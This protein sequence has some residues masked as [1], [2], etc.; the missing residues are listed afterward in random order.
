MLIQPLDVV[1]LESGHL[2][3]G[4]RAN[5]DSSG[6][7][8]CGVSLATCERITN[9]DSSSSTPK[10]VTRTLPERV[11]QPGRQ[12]FAEETSPRR[13]ARSR[14]MAHLL[15]SFHSGRGWQ[16]ASIGWREPGRPLEF[17]QHAQG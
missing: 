7:M 16:T 8:D 1:L 12:K 3:T 15:P 11:A 9:V 4:S 10:Y 5:G 6:S 13:A 2:E 17:E 14:A